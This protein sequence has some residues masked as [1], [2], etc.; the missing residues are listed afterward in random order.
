METDPTY[1]MAFTQHAWPQKL[2]HGD[3]RWPTFNADFCNRE[4]EVLDIANAIYNGHAYTTWHRN[5][6]REGENYLTGQHLALDF[7]TEDQRST[8]GALAKDPF[9]AKYAGLIY[10]TPSHKPE[11]PR[12]RVLFLLDTPIC[13]AKNYTL[14]SM[15]LLWLY[16]TADR[17]CKD[18]CRFFYGSTNCEVEYLD[19]V[20]P[21]VKV[22][23]V[24]D[25][26]QASGA[27]AKKVNSQPRP[28]S[29]DQAEVAAALAKVPAWGIDYDEWVTVLM[30]LHAAFGDAALPLAES[31]AQGAP[32]EVERKW[33]SFHDR[34]NGAGCV[35]IAS[36]F[37]LAKR[38]GWQKGM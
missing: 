16:G 26:Y 38:Y 20:L 29:A 32:N 37:G 21:L 9:I 12:A 14:A 13:Q 19:H 18:P 7:D 8:L 30:A 10:T 11:A 36:V 28:T 22:R 3:P 24:I 4:L 34:G 25:Q 35:T 15:A 27:L 5:H 17:K 31:W 2:E 6:W 1:R 33:K 23:Q